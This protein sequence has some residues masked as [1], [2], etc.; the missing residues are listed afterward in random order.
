MEPEIGQRGAAPGVLDAGP[1]QGGVKVIGP[2]HE[3]GSRFH[4][5]AQLGG[6]SK[7]GQSVFFIDTMAD[8]PFQQNAEQGATLLALDTRDLYKHLRGLVVKIKTGEPFRDIG[9][10]EPGFFAGG[11]GDF[12]GRLLR[13]QLIATVLEQAGFQIE[14]RGDLL[15]ARDAGPV[16]RARPSLGV[17]LV[18][19]LRALEPPDLHGPQAALCAVCCPAAVPAY[20]CNGSPE[21]H[22]ENTEI[23]IKILMNKATTI[24]KN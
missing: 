23:N 12:S 7:S 15:D 8:T 2:V 4:L 1:G 22:N 5:L 19:G 11:G 21:K 18:L 14:T 6:G 13:L 24:F 20:F 9:L 10:D 3:H 17:P 16:G